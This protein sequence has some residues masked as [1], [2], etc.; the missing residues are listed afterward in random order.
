MLGSCRYLG[1]VLLSEVVIS[2]VLTCL[3]SA[4]ASGETLLQRNAPFGCSPPAFR[5]QRLARLLPA[6]SGGRE[7]RMVPGAVQ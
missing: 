1:R 2:F 6:G 7:V 5:G 3:A 4:A